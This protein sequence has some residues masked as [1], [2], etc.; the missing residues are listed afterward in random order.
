MTARI[1][2]H[3]AA[4]GRD[5]LIDDFTINPQSL[6]DLA[7]AHRMTIPALAKWAGAPM[8]RRTL[9][10]I[11]DLSDARTDLIVSHART[12]AAHALRRLAVDSE[13]A[14]T[15]RK[16]CVDLLRLGIAPAPARARAPKPAPA[17]GAHEAEAVDHDALRRVLEAY[18]ERPAHERHEAEPRPGDH[19]A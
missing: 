5:T 2:V 14:E 7:R 11:R 8:N 9:E 3:P 15:Q 19:A 6:A 17:D 12:E 18:A 1:P 4:P 10:A 16:A 13:S